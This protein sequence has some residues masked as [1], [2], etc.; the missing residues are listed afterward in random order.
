M[1]DIMEQCELSLGD[2]GESGKFALEDLGLTLSPGSQSQPFAHTM[3]FPEFDLNM[4]LDFGLMDNF[5]PLTDFDPIVH[6]IDIPILAPTPTKRSIEEVSP[7]EVETPP[8]R[9]CQSVPSPSSSSSLETLA[10]Q[11]QSRM[12]LANRASPMVSTNNFST[13]GSSNPAST[14]AMT[15]FGLDPDNTMDPVPT[16]PRVVPF[17]SPYQ[18]SKYYPSAPS[19]HTRTVNV[20]V[21]SSALQHRLK[22][23]HSRIN[24]L[25][26]ER[27]RYRDKF[28]SYSQPDPRTGKLKIDE[29]EAEITTLRRV[30]STQQTRTRNLKTELQTW[31]NDYTNLARTHNNLLADYQASQKSPTLSSR[32]S[33]EST[34]CGSEPWKGAYDQLLAEHRSLIS[35][36]KAPGV[37]LMQ[38][39]ERLGMQ[40]SNK[41][42]TTSYPSPASISSM[43][44]RPPAVPH[45]DSVVIDLT[46][47][48]A[49]DVSTLGFPTVQLSPPVNKT[50]LTDFRHTLRHKKLDWIQP[51]LTVRLAPQAL[52][53]NTSPVQ[54]SGSGSASN[55]GRS[56][57][58]PLPMPNQK[59]SGN[60]ENAAL[61]SSGVARMQSSEQPN[62][63]VRHNMGMAST[64]TQTH[65]QTLASNVQV[66]SRVLSRSSSFNSLFDERLEATAAPCDLL[67]ENAFGDN[68][69]VYMMEQIP[70]NED[71]HPDYDELAR[72]LEE[73]L[74]R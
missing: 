20:E 68:Q 28:L 34:I 53:D 30:K 44:N 60:D 21:S 37:D 8:K 19:L 62:T 39:L 15:R 14:A 64:D 55:Q 17:L 71:Y 26:I 5:D 22:N 42:S 46:D 57:V 24:V 70:G 67:P 61:I 48:G 33:P 27:N 36:L 18:V 65:S 25:V 6:Q 43:P 59:N 58:A 3:D 69:P 54:I 73:E 16:L 1:N 7:D 12:D 31:Q 56:L 38:V 52:F 41:P 50:Q 51:Q 74:A 32:Q 49:E 45:Q 29:M 47:D 66:N 35:A 10:M 2:S 23:C 72:M 9:S 13:A 11:T 4:D 40:S 63:Q